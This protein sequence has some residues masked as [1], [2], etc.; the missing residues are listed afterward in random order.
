MHELICYYR[1]PVRQKMAYRSTDRRKVVKHLLN[2][3]IHVND[4]GQRIEFHENG[5]NIF[6]SEGNVVRAYRIYDRD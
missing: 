1:N 2:I 4:M 3:A 5:I 6:S